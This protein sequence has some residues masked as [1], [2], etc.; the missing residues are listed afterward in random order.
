MSP[1]PKSPSAIR[2]PVDVLSGSGPPIHLSFLLEFP[3]SVTIS[4][5]G[6]PQ[7]KLPPRAV[8]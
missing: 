2:T 5:V 7:K 4:G 1:V 6:P 8:G 3:E